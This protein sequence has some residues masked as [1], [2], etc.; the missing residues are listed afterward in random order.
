[1][2]HPDDREQFRAESYAFALRMGQDARLFEKSKEIICEAEKYRYPYLWTWLGAPIIQMPAD[3]VTL[4]EAVWRSKPDIIIETGIARGGSVLFFASLLELIGKGKVIGVDIDIR[5]HNRDTIENHPMSKRVHLIEG[6]SIAPETAGRV[7]AQIPAG[8]SVMVVLDS[9]HS[10]DHVLAELRAY[11]PLVTQGQYLIVA[12]TILGFLAREQTPT[13]CSKV[14]YE[15]D[16]PL[17]ALR[18]FTAE[19]DD[20]ELDMELNGKLI[21]GSS[22]GGYLRRK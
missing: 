8:A 12:D 1:M 7:S 20:F 10:R 2:S 11:A 4:Q 21:M 3:I 5:A 13:G 18:L 6:S 14:W 22:P 15:G 19:C 16:E 9:D 17:S